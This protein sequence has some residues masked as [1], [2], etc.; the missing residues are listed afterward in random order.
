MLK[1]WDGLG[2]QHNPFFSVCSF[3]SVFSVVNV[4]L[5]FVQKISLKNRISKNTIDKL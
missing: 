2:K 4:F 3:S 5:I 1:N